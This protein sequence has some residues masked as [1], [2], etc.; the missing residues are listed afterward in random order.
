[1]VTG[2]TYRA[3]TPSHSD[4]S[5]LVSMCCVAM[6]ILLFSSVSVR[7]YFAKPLQTALFQC[8]DSLAFSPLQTFSQR[9][10]LAKSV[11]MDGEGRVW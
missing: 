3:I 4:I 1:M 9:K 5:P 2:W 7:C 11:G 6:D 8:I 10:R